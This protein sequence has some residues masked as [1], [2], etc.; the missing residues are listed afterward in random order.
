MDFKES[1]DKLAKSGNSFL[2]NSQYLIPDIINCSSNID[3]QQFQFYLQQYHNMNPNNNFNRKY[4]FEFS[5]QLLE[6]GS[7]QEKQNIKIKNNNYLNGSG[8]INSQPEENLSNSVYN[9]KIKK[10]NKFL[11]KS[12]YVG[13]ENNLGDNSCYVNTVLHLL[14]NITDV[15][16]ILKDISIIENLNKPYKKILSQIFNASDSVSKEE[17][18][19]NCGEILSLYDSFQ[20]RKIKE[21][22]VIILNSL[23]L[24]KNLDKFSD[25]LFQLNHSADPV[26]LLLFILDLLN[27]SYKQQIHNNFYLNLIDQSNCPKRCKSSMKVRFDKDNFCYH[28]Y[29]NELLSF[30]KEEKKTFKEKNQNLFDLSLDAYKKE[31]KICEKCS[32]LNDKYLICYSVPKYLLINC[33]WGYR[34]EQKDIL[35]FLFLLSIEEDLKRLFI[36]D[37]SKEDTTYNLLGMILYSYSLCHYTII[38]Y[39]KKEKVFVFHDD[40]I[41]I[42]FKTLYD[43]YSQILLDYIQKYE[44]KKAYFYPTLLLYTKENIYNLNDIKINEL[45]EFKYVQ[46]LNKIEEC[47]K[48]YN[49]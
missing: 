8:I 24:R 5:G 41:I 3:P 2:E 46:M 28:L 14:E 44:N 31:I 11:T 37:D 9:I 40:E 43:C 27:A 38:L 10:E 33:I 15:N 35:D 45:N 26:E 39:N 30:I 13:F 6:N 18:L 49:Y 21:K 1:E 16:N 42:E 7:N 25:H 12:C 36:C 19:A 32:E 48:K 47:Q 23:E 17:F 20:N 34:P 22:D 29:I 4:H